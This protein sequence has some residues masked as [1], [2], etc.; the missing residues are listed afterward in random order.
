MR[1]FT[2]DDAQRFTN[3]YYRPDN[4]I[5]FVYGNVE[6]SQVVALLQ[7]HTESIVPP[8][9]LCIGYTEDATNTLTKIEDTYEPSTIVVD[10]KTHQAHVMMGTRSYSVHDERR[11]VTLFAEQYSWWSWYE[12][13]FKPLVART[14]WIGLF[15]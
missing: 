14:E 11:I 13:A 10:K 3:K 8:N 1:Q 9:A 5:F 15:G 12:Y 2:S 7:Q 6:F 4:A